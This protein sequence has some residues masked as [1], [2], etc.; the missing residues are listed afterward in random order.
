MSLAVGQE[1]IPAVPPL[2]TTFTDI[3]KAFGTLSPEMRKWIVIAG[4][5]AAVVGPLLVGFAAIAGAIGTLAP[6]LITVGGALDTVLSIGGTAIAAIGYV[7]YANWDA[8]K[9]VLSSGVAWIKSAFSS[10][11]AQLRQIG[12]MMMQGLLLAINP[13]ALGVKLIAMAKN[14]IT[15]FKNYLGIKSPSRLMMQMGDH[16]ATGLGHGIDGAAGGPQRAMGRLAGGISGASAR[17]LAPA[18]QPAPV[19]QGGSTFVFKISQQPGEDGE[20]LARRVAKMV[21]QAQKQRKLRSYQ[22]DY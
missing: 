22:D 16:V 19:T 18:A 14:G 13:L 6:I 4:G 15:V 9:S 5:V 8:I 17:Q 1:L 21:D 11:P 3:I 12:T 10:L 7:I 20:A 2:I